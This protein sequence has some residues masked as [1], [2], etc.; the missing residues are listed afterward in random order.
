MK[1]IIA[2]LFFVLSPFFMG[3]FACN[4]NAGGSLETSVKSA[5]VIVKAKI[6]SISYSD[7]LDTLNVVPEGDP[8][9]VF[10]KYWRFQVKIY[11]AVVMKNYKGEISSDT[12]SIVTGINGAACG[13]GMGINREYLVYGF[14]K[15]YLG[16]SSVQRRATDDR[17]IW[18][19]NCTRTWDY[20]DSESNDIVVEVERQSYKE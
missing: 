7:R 2:C 10:S 4:C 13:I 17:L 5:D 8:K 1:K 20:S 18:T 9:N 15:D 3:L 19:N 12:I 6:I 16:F 14:K 11:R